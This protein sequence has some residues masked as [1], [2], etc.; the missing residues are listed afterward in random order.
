MFKSVNDSNGTNITYGKYFSSSRLSKTTAN[1]QRN[2]FF[3]V[4]FNTRS[5]SKNLDKIEEF[6]N[7]MT[8]FPDAI[9]ISETKL[10]SNSSSNNN[11]PH[12]NFLH[13]N[14]PTNA[15]GVGFYFKDTLQCR[16]RDDLSLNLPNCEDLWI[17]IKC[18]MSDI[19]L[20]VI[21]R[22]P[23]KEISSFQNKICDRISSLELSK[24]N[25]V[26][27]GDTNINTLENTNKTIDYINAL[28]SIGC[29]MTIRNPTRFANNCSPSLL[30]HVYTNISSKNTSSGVSMFEISD[31]L[32]LFFL[33]KHSKCDVKK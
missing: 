11:I 8:R 17:Q 10:N 2:D 13:N 23:D 3:L 22:H 31:P 1:L 24:S 26:I 32:P 19:I 6:L 21:Y 4:H 18:K 5:L 20:A 25:Y 16:L 27:C 9:A 14:W 29:K 15:G 7:A 30:D 33:L 28:T 12:Y